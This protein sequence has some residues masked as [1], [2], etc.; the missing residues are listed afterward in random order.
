MPVVS[1][2]RYF[3]ISNLAFAVA[4]VLCVGLRE[5][6][7]VG[8]IASLGSILYG[9]YAL[10]RPHEDRHL[11]YIIPFLFSASAFWGPIFIFGCDPEI[12]QI[13]YVFFPL[14]ALIFV[15]I[16]GIL[17]AVLIPASAL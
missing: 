10:R 3:W 8:V 12:Q 5:I 17:T 1:N 9:V 7:Y 15:G 6:A 2:R 11:I 16:A 14:A 13:D 4:A